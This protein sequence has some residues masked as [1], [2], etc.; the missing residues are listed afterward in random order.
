MNLQPGALCRYRYPYRVIRFLLGLMDMACIVLKKVSGCF[1]CTY[2][3][4][5]QTCSRLVFAPF[6]F[7][8]F[9]SRL[10]HL[11]CMRYGILGIFLIL[12]VIISGC[13]QMTTPP[14]ATTPFPT[15]LITTPATLPPV[16]SAIPVA[17]MQINITAK[18]SGSDV[19]VQY[20]GGADAAYLTALNIRIDNSNGQIVKQ[21]FVAPAIPSTYT[22]PYI[23][24]ADA[25]VVN[26]VGVFNGGSE[27]TVL[28]TSV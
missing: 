5:I 6:I 18:Q 17:P 23:G 2:A 25:D 13:T 4:I 14:A 15:P 22:F 8:T 21:T 12:A 10:S 27:Q 24:T 9:I 3:W 28:L 1:S 11:T 19:I 7:T 16:T 20:N 26:V